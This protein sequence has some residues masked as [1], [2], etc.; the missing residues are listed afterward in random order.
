M[1]LVRVLEGSGRTSESNPLQSIPPDSFEQ[2]PTY[3]FTA[4]SLDHIIRRR[5]QKLS[6]DR[7]LVHIYPKH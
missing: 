5:A 3:I 7:E 4:N 1:V 2:L 6:D